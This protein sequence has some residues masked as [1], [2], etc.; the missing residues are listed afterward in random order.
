MIAT[1][2][3]LLPLSPRLLTYARV[4]I[5]K[6]FRS[7]DRTRIKLTRGALARVASGFFMRSH[8]RSPTLLAE[9]AN[10]KLQARGLLDRVNAPIGAGREFSRELF[11]SLLFFAGFFSSLSF[12]I[13]VAPLRSYRED[14]SNSNLNQSI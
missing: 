12:K 9:Q 11:L 14:L 1:F 6:I 7:G 2:K 3:I 4:V 5:R 8:Y 10:R 13:G